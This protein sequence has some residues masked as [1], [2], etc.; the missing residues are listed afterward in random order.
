MKRTSWPHAIIT[1]LFA[2]ALHAGLSHVSEP[3]WRWCE[4]L[5]VEV[6]Q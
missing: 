4:L 1:A 5:C 6:C 3:R 2:I